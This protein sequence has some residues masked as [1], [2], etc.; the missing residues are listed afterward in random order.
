MAWRHLAEINRFGPD[1]LVI[2]PDATL[3]RQSHTFESYRVRRPHR[4][5]T[6]SR[7]DDRQI[8]G[9][10]NENLAPPSAL[11]A[12]RNSPPCSRTIP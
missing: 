3:L 4:L 12:A 10:A 11:F 7:T 6:G 1:N 2:V 9:N 5:L 8:D